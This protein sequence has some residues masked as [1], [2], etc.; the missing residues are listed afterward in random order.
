MVQNKIRGQGDK[1]K[2]E[3]KS[4]RR[5]FL[6]DKILKEPTTP[7]DP[8][9]I[10]SVDDILNSF[11]NLGFQARS[12][13][14]A[15]V[16]WRKM[17]GEET[18]IFLGLAGAMVP[19][20]LRRL[21][22][23]LIKLRAIDCLV[24]TGANLFHDTHETLGKFHYKGDHQAD[25]LRLRKAG[26]DRIYDVFASEEE[27]RQTDNYV[28]NFSLELNWTKDYSTREFLYLL[29]QKLLQENKGEGIL[30]EA[31]K[32]KVPIYCP[33]IS[34]S[35]LGMS[36]AMAKLRK[37]ARFPLDV[38]EDILEITEIAH[39]AKETGVI[40]IGG[41]T[42]KNFIQQTAVMAEFLHGGDCGHKHALQ[43][44]TDSPHWGGLSGCTFQEAQSWG[45]VKEKAKM[46]TV[47]SDAT[48]AFPLLSTSIIGN[49]QLL[50]ERIRP[51]LDFLNWS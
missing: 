25:D 17:L 18:T 8:E 4:E 29:G 43:I 1:V 28:E 13:A 41:G 5:L 16:I 12:L 32:S 3:N 7:V 50:Q 33:A 11:G 14:Q 9:E 42:P 27:F 45:K 20:G 21:V 39:Q 44:I 24:S 40:Y 10:K 49:K 38:L 36:L 35:C 51:S 47:Y 46:V 15:V 22:Q 30:T 31:Y 26:I 37:G 34:D 19:A 48:I 23:K 2:K 6:K